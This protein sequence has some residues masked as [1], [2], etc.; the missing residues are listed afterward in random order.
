MKE[1]F[2]HDYN[3]RND[4]ELVNVF[5]K[6]QLTGIG[7]FWCIVEMLYESNGYIMLSECDRIAFELRINK[8][9]IIELIGNENLFKQDKKK[10]W[11]ESVLKRLNLR[12][13]KSEKAK[14]SASIRWNNAFALQTQTESNAIKVN[15]IKENKSKINILNFDFIE[16]E[17]SVCFLEWID[18]KKE[19]KQ[20]Y[21]TQKSL[22]SCYH[23]LKL[24]SDVDPEKA[25]QIV[26]NSISNNYS[27]LFKLKSDTKTQKDETRNYIAN[28]IIEVTSRNK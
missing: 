8:E 4:P 9:E 18:Y 2:S 17:Y 12:N 16:S 25:K 5:M 15:K 21:K 27:G 24:L 20:S 3:A 22:E 14:R 11:S 13:E 7:L 19:K 28:R 6:K 1:Y 23:N 10:F 26:F